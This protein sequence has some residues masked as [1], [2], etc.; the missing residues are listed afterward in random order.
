M[1]RVDVL[2]PAYNAA[3][4]V[5]DAIESLRAQTL[6][7]IRIIVVDDGS[8]DATPAILAELAALEPRLVVVT[9]QNEGI[10][11]ARNTALRHA[12]ADF[13]ACLDS[14][15]IAFPDRLERTLAYLNAHPEC[16]AVG[17]AVAH[18]DEHGAPL[19]GLQ[20]SGPPGDAD[21][22]KA[23][24]LEPYIV[25][26]TL[27]ARRADVVAV[28]GYRHA[29]NSE[30]SDLFWR[31]AERGALVNLPDA[32]GKYR[33]HTA[34]ISSTLHNGRI[35]ALGSQL[36][37]LSALRRGAG[38]SDIAFPRA[39]HEALK[40]AP[41]LEAMV[42]I[43]AADLETVE[44]QHLRIATACKLMELARYRP[45][46]PDRADC[47]FIRAALA[48]AAVLSSQNQKEVAWYVTVTAARLMGKGMLAE[49]FTLTPPKHY[50]MTGARMLLGR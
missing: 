44:A 7:D 33:V 20:Q 12:D 11:E 16:V 28:G 10:V 50:A 46:E 41:T 27:M 19:S 42:Q 17:G 15:D 38:R 21:A 9:K 43:A 25:Q 47:A 30:D 48:Y 5:R 1:A 49:A 26:S 14:D 37:A 32:L 8:T 22:A 3:A 2:M 35:M 4:T 23:P 24:A 31:L 18:M 39:L 6:Q 40:Q 45:F 29:P 36:G 13:I 34:S